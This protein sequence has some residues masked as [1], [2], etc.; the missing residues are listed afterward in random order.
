M[1]LSYKK[2]LFLYF[3]LVFTVFT[4]LIVLVQRNRERVYK[5]ETLR[6]NLNTYAE[7]IDRYIR[8]RKLHAIPGP[9]SLRQLLPLLPS[10][11]RITVIERQGKVLFDNTVADEQG[12][13]NHLSR[14]EISSALVQGDGSTIRFS[15][16]NSQDYYYYALFSDP[17]FIRVAL[18]YNVELQNFLKGDNVF[19]YFILLLFFTAL[20]SLLYL[21]DRFGKAISGLKDF[22]TSTENRHPDYDKIKFPDTELGEIGNKII[23]NHKLLEESREQ[24]RQ[25]KE[26]LLRHFHYSEEGICIFSENCR[27]IYANTHFIQYLNILVDEPMFEVDSIFN[28]PDFRELRIFLKKHTPVNPQASTLPVYQGKISKNGKHFAVKLLIFTDNCFEI[29][30]NNI[31]SAEKNRLLKQEMTNNIA[32][33]LKTPVSSIRGYIETLLEQQNI[34]PDKRK[35][36]L[37]RTYTQ[38]TRLSELIRDVALITKTEEAADLFEKE[39]VNLHDTLEEIAGDLG[40]RLRENHITIENHVDETVEIEGNHTLLYSIFRNL[41]DNAISY[42]GTN[43]TVC[44]DQYLE[45]NEFYYFSLY[46]TGCGVGE[47]HLERIF[48]RFYRINEGRSRKTGGSGLG[49]SIVK[50]AVLFHK[51]QISAKNRKNGGLEFIFSLRKKLY[52]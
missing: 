41:I 48:D 21:S 51:G 2:K 17:Y 30:L 10:D 4:V 18:P 42:A 44:I 22:I 37:E 5:T 26:K 31:S 19:F 24:L 3:F 43:I 32:H 12:L 50:N 25:E 27:K 15:R 8:Y 7:T 13:E 34:D 52:G 1:H 46:D 6:T 39:T 20:L 11:L 45:D 47:E 38:V 29:T 28:E 49:L 36:F 40:D 9:D 33:E 35:F 14:P 16:T 23:T